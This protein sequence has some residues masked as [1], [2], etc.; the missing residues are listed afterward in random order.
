MYPN[1]RVLYAQ[2]ARFLA[3]SLAENQRFEVLTAI[4]FAQMA[5]PGEFEVDGDM[6]VMNLLA[7]EQVE[8]TDCTSLF[9][10]KGVS[11]DSDNSIRYGMFYALVGVGDT[12]TT[13]AIWVDIHK[14]PSHQTN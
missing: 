11:G 5:P 2:L 14:S 12:E 3:F 9:H 8:V 7:K 6:W 4:W 13:V 10:V 1:A